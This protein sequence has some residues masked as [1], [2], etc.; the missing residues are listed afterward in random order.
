MR[1][2]NGDG[3]IR[4]QQKR[5][6]F[7][8]NKNFDE[9]WRHLLFRHGSPQDHRDDL[10]RINAGHQKRKFYRINI[11]QLSF[12]IFFLIF[13]YKTYRGEEYDYKS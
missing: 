13:L 1:N 11:Y 4:P 6:R 2:V 7:V 10:R 3:N 9:E 12:F 8:Q 5:D